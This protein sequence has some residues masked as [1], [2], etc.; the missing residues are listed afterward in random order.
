MKDKAAA[1]LEVAPGQGPREQVV[2]PQKLPPGSKV[3]SSEGQELMGILLAHVTDNRLDNVLSKLPTPPTKKETGQVCGMLCKDA[4][5]DF[6]KD[7]GDE[8]GKLKPKEQK[9]IQKVFGRR[10]MEVVSNKLK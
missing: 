10:A 7:H 2:K 4:L 3:K 5:D 9:E 6:H 1:F 8:Y